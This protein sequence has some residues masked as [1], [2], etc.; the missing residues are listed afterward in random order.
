[1]TTSKRQVEVFTAGCPACDET[2]QMVQ[3]IVCESCEVTVLDMND[4]TVAER[5]KEIGVSR[6]PAVVVNGQLAGC[7]TNAG[8]NA[9]TLRGTGIGQAL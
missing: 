5:A 8:P 7:C 6:V 4:A 9:Q 1:M 2:V 3:G